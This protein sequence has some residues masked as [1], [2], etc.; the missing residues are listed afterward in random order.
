MKSAI[1]SVLLLMVFP[2][3]FCQESVIIEDKF[4]RKDLSQEEIKQNEIRDSLSNEEFSKALTSQLSVLLSGQETNTL[5]N[6]AAV[7]I[8]DAAVKFSPSFV[9]ENGNLITAELKAGITDG[10]S[11]IFSNNKLNTNVSLE[12]ALNLGNPYNKKS[13]SFNSTK[14]QVFQGLKHGLELEKNQKLQKVIEFQ[15]DTSLK[16][17]ELQD[18]IKKNLHQ[19][20]KESDTL[21][22]KNKI[23]AALQLNTLKIADK[24]KESIKEKDKTKLGQLRF[25]IESLKLENINYNKQ[26]K[27][28]TSAKYRIELLKDKNAALQ[29]QISA[30]EEGKEARSIELQEELID[31]EYVKKF[32]ELKESNQLE[33]TGVQMDWYT[34]F[35]KVKNDAFSLFDSSKTFENQ[36]EKHNE[37][38]HEFGFQHS[39]YRHELSSSFK[40][41]FIT[42]G[43]NFSFTNNLGELDQIEV[44]DTTSEIN[45]NV[46]RVSQSKTN[47]FIGPL[48][49]DIKRLNLFSDLYYFLYK[50]KFALHFNPIHGIQNKR[51]PQTDFTFG[52]LFSF[53]NPNE[54]KISPVNVE[55]FYSFLDVFKNTDTD[56]RHF[57]R[58][59]IGLRFTF[60]INFKL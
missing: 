23:N 41:F 50:N 34:I 1:L 14:W 22:A 37:V 17:A 27:D 32:N 15:E 39:I 46:N 43:V 51:K 40:T 4:S 47:A 58:N 54:K 56:L 3:T 36:I 20:E 45:N 13:L 29:R 19:I 53:K 24:E 44:V 11:P 55:A 12:I 21:A 8:V 42:S 35:Y 38:S 25:D 6:F 7:D 52:F 59:N 57:E 30:L 49:D 16:I 60:P 31:A 9:L 2:Y 33:V 5:G 18:A 10:F 26:L 28:F 48:E